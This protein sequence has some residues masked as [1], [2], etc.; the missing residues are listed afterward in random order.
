M[1]KKIIITMEEKKVEIF[2]QKRKP[3]YLIICAARVGGIIENRDNSLEFLLNN[4]FNEVY[5]ETNLVPMPKGNGSIRL[6][7][8]F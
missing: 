3:E 8:S 1:I 5:T 7:F 2:F 6:E 4:I